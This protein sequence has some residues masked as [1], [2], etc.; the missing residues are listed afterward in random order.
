MPEITDAL[1]QDQWCENHPEVPPAQRAAA[2][3]RMRD[4]FYTDTPEWKQRIVEQGV[5]AA[6]Q[7]L[8]G[9]AGA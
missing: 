5:D 6:R 9:L 1:R 3:Q 7:A 2:R 4:A 8:A